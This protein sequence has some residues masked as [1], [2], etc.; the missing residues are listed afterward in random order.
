M[1]KRE[2][3]LM[4]SKAELQTVL[5]RV[6]EESRHIYGKKLSRIILYGS[7]ARGDNTD[8]SDVDIMILLDCDKDEVE[9]LREKTYEMAN[10]ISLDEDVF[11][12]V[13]LRDKKHFEENQDFL[14]FYRNI[15]KDGV[16]IYG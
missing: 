7:Y 6:R 15:V 4:C 16:S 8:E 1:L 14:S 5:G 10:D 12:S 13:L 11:L 2:L 3:M 9:E